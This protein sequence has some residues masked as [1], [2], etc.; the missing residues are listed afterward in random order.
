MHRSLCYTTREGGAYDVVFSHDTQR[1]K[2]YAV[3][4]N[5]QEYIVERT[6][7]GEWMNYTR[8][9]YGT[10][11]YNVYLRV[12]C[13]LSQQLSLDVVGATTNNL[14]LFYTTN[15]FGKSNFRY[16][17]LLNSSGNSGRG[18][19]FRHKEAPADCGRAAVR[20]IQTGLKPKLHGVLCGRDAGH[21]A[22]Y[23]H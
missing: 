8:T 12:G 15:A 4:P 14:G 2:Y 11:Y 17:P 3:D 23:S 9:F 16:E 10:N 22:G 20:K 7:G 19:S 1:Q 5:L 18:E 21:R 6:E 13:E